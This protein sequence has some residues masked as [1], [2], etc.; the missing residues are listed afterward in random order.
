MSIYNNII[1]VKQ[2]FPTIKVGVSNFFPL[3]N[4]PIT[5][6]NESRDVDSFVWRINNGEV[7][8]QNSTDSSVT[9]SIKT[10]DKTTQSLS[11]SNTVGSLMTEK[12][13]YALPYPAEAYYEF[14][15]S[16][17]VARENEIVSLTLR[18]KYDFTEDA[19]VVAVV[20]DHISGTQIMS[21]TMDASTKEFS[22]PDVGIYDI[23][24]QTTSNSYT[25]YYRMGMALTVTKALSVKENALVHDILP[26]AECVGVYG[27]PYSVIDGSNYNFTG[28]GIEPGT[29]I[30]LNK[31]VDGYPADSTY[32]LRIANLHGTEASP[33]I[34]TIDEDAPLNIN[35][36]S[37]W[38]VLVDN[39]SHII[40][41][42]RGYKNIVNGINIHRGDGIST[43]VIALQ[44][45]NKSTDIEIHNVECHDCDFSGITVKT[46][47]DAN[48][49][50]TWRKT[51]DNPN[52]FELYNLKIHN[53]YM[54]HTNGEGNYIGYYDAGTITHA[55]SSGNVH[56]YRAHKLIDT[57]IY[58]N[59]YYRCGWDSIQLNNS[60]GNTE[61]RHNTIV[62]S[63]W[64]GETNQNT[65]MS[66]TMEGE[67]SD[68]IIDGCSGIGIQ[69]GLL[70]D[71]KLHTNVISGL[72]EGVG[73][74][75][76]LGGEGRVEETNVNGTYSNNLLFDVF[77]N[78][79]IV[80]GN[81]I[82]LSAQNVVQYMGVRYRNN[83]AQ[84]NDGYLFGGQ[85]N[86]TLNAW[87]LNSANNVKINPANYSIYKIGSVPDKVFNIYPDSELST[88]GVVTDHMYDIRGYKN[89][90]VDTKFVGAY[91]GIT[92]MP[93]NM[94]Q[95]LSVSINNGS[96]STRS[97]NVQLSYSAKGYPTQYIVSED[98][99]FG[100][101]TWNNVTVPI[102]FTLSENDGT[103][104]I[105]MKLRNNSVDSSVL[106]SSIYYSET[107]KYLINLAP[108]NLVYNESSPWNNFNSNAAEI[109]LTISG[110]LDQY[111][112][113]S[114]LSATVT[115]PF[116][117][118]SSN[119]SP[120]E[121]YP[122]PAKTVA[123][124]WDVFKTG[125]IAGVGTISIRG[126]NPNKLY[127]V[128][129][130]SNKEYGGGNMIYSV[131]G[132]EQ[133][134]NNEFANRNN[135][136]TFVNVQPIDG[137]ISI[138]V[139]PDTILSHDGNIGVIDIRERNATPQLNG[140]VINNG[141][142]SVFNT[143]VDVTMDVSLYPSQYILSES[144]TFSNSNWKTYV[145]NVV[146]YTF[147]TS[148]IETKTV[149]AKVKNSAGESAVKSDTI[150]YL[151]PKIQLD[152]IQL[153]YGSAVT[154]GE[155]VVVSVS[156]SNGTP[157][158]YMISESPNF[159]GASWISWSGSTF[160]Y[161]LSASGLRTIY[162]RIKDS[163]YETLAAQS[164]ITYFLLNLNSIVING[165]ANVTGS[166]DVSVG[167]NYSGSVPTHYML[168]ED[169]SF[170]GISWMQFIDASVS[171]TMS[172]GYGIKT[173]YGT[174]KDSYTTCPSVYDT[175]NFA[176][177][178]MNVTAF[179]INNLASE[180]NNADVSVYFQ[181]E[182]EPYQYMI[183]ESSS[184]IG[185]SWNSFTPSPV[186]YSFTESSYGTKNLYFKLRTL[187]GF[188]SSVASDSIDY[189]M[190]KIVISLSAS[191]YADSYYPTYNGET[192]NVIEHVKNES[193]SNFSLKD[194]MGTTKATYVVKPSE[195][196]ADSS[197]LSL[198]NMTAL[199]PVLSGNAGVYPDL[200]ISKYYYQ[201][202]SNVLG[203]KG[204][205]RLKDVQP[206][207]YTVN[208][209]K[210]SQSNNYVES[211]RHYINIVAND[212]APVNPV[213]DVSNNVSLFTTIRGVNV[214]DNG[215]LDIYFFNETSGLYYMPGLNLIEIKKERLIETS[216]R[217]LIDLGSS[218]SGRNSPTP[219]NNF[220][221]AG[222]GSVQMDSSIS[223][224]TSS[225]R[226]SNLRLVVDSSNWEVMDNASSI[227]NS[228]YLGTAIRDSFGV[229]YPGVGKMK[230]TGCD[231]TKTYTIKILQSKSFAGADISTTV[232]G[233]TQIQ[234][235][236]GN[237]NPLTWTTT[238]V[239]GVIDIST[240]S[241]TSGRYSQINI[242][243]INES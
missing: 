79:F 125:S 130:Y 206:G 147:N 145:S 16:T 95:L 136:C 190:L 31:L 99:S 236:T 23:E 166:Q 35:F 123:R 62:D 201:T 64:L 191:T 98:P 108:S 135:I 83:L 82:V 48:D 36:E 27:V 162:V 22:L 67:V 39:C 63:A 114:G 178:L 174:I 93:D 129:M 121:L 32:R 56:T 154:Y 220:I 96:P 110:L 33:I 134:Y 226:Y 105:Y 189:N 6:T 2:A 119:A 234:D 47:P 77:N 72:S 194:T 192:I 81:G 75:M 21:I 71:T 167:I 74:V 85:D 243:D 137:S 138:S 111:G 230:I 196:P 164:S 106:S 197:I 239:N 183:S 221:V 14:D 115:S 68:N 146:Q 17:H 156:Y 157:T 161:A 55:D 193:L 222:N 217:Y 19:S 61:I 208:I 216:V 29:T 73:C 15:V 11:V 34:I 240:A 204:L 120:S 13:I 195:M 173:V 160:N 187:A 69:I 153:N 24:M 179:Y 151:G 109:G 142:V 126:C 107:L 170:M 165:N 214:T 128:L 8:T 131:N 112:S 238:S 228:T 100:S 186:N 235:I 9:F 86:N 163:N 102:N 92:K 122:Y 205:I 168:S 45:I 76:L 143:T 213:Q 232:N 3:L 140:I 18:N 155:N 180:T 210:S 59:S 172:N 44:C 88:G 175:I 26:T 229:L 97:R 101:S 4:Q 218:A 158:H 203:N 182:G 188:E 152:G 113:T 139:K 225:A 65:G 169:P 87:A 43:A 209:L 104:T 231:D 133:S 52:G 7:I 159:D 57:K 53:T 25:V 49:P 207:E 212:S 144:S 70:G 148:A 227:D 224:F 58:R 30:V 199:N 242:I 84:Y 127:D 202:D 41:D 91:A 176:E 233:S 177:S 5:L 10:A 184:F 28:I 241:L 237:L 116:D 94:L 198:S 171:Y 118:I 60:Y 141:D 89:W 50:T 185:A 200:F 42:G 211:N 103:K 66:L 80:N 149:Y 40:I 78:N 132:T 12:N 1:N 150:S 51:V 90:V 219:Y 117:G 223:L 20:S 38:G 124:N 54:H 181:Y 215:M 37:W 46:D